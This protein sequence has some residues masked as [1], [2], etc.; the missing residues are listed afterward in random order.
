MVHLFTLETLGE[1]AHE[2]IAR[3]YVL[4]ERGGTPRMQMRTDFAAPR[5]MRLAEDCDGLG[6]LNDR[7]VDDVRGPDPEAVAQG[8]E[9]FDRQY[10]P[11]RIAVPWE[12]A[13]PKAL[14]LG[15]DGDD[16]GRVGHFFGTAGALRSGNSICAN[17][18]ELTGLIARN[19]V[20][21]F[22]SGRRSVV[23]SM[24]L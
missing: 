18:R 5:V 14:L 10:V 12:R 19:S 15:I 17:F 4:I 1:V 20:C 3:S 24:P 11:Y 22:F 2:R 8:L 21:L 16:Q 9:A 7:C 13:A 6:V 23:Y